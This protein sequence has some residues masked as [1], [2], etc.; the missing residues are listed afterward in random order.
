[1]SA[2]IASPTTLYVTN[3][4]SETTN[5]LRSTLSNKTAFAIIEDSCFG[6]TLDAGQSC[7]VS[8]VF[9]GTAAAAAVNAD[10]TVSDGSTTSTNNT[11][12]AYL[13]SPVTARSAR[14]LTR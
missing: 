9:T 13:K 8:V 1:M 7:A 11:V 10:L 5:L 2:L 12:T 6:Q 3:M 4:G 14:A